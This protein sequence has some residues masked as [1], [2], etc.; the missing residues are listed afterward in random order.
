MAMYDEGVKSMHSVYEVVRLWLNKLKED[1]FDYGN[2][3]YAHVIEIGQVEHVNLLIVGEFNACK[4]D[5]HRPDLRSLILFCLNPLLSF[6]E[7]MDSIKS[8]RLISWS[9]KW[10]V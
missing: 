7:M 5:L 1:N 4:V 8:D 10:I 2:T 6:P 9:L 3:N